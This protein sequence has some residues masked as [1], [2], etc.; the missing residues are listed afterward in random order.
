MAV[1]PIEFTKLDKWFIPKSETCTIEYSVKGFPPAAPARGARHAPVKPSGKGTP[2]AVTPIRPPRPRLDF[3]VYASNYCKAASAAEG[4]FLKYTFSA[5]AVPILETRGLP[6]L[7]PKKK[8][9][10]TT[11][12]GESKATEGVLK[13]RD[14]Q[15]RYIN[16]AFSPYTTHLRYYTAKESKDALLK[17]EPFWPGFA[18]TAPHAVDAASLK[19]KWK[20]TGDTG[21]KVKSGLVIV[22][23]NTDTEVYRSDLL[24]KAAVD[25]GEFDL[26][27]KWDKTKITRDKMPYRAQVIAYSKEIC[28]AAMHTEVRLFVHGDVGKDAARPLEDP[29]CLDLAVAPFLPHKVSDLPAEGTAEWYRLKL[30]EGGFHPGPVGKDAGAAR[31][32]LALKEFQR[33]Y[34]KDGAAPH[35]RIKADGSKNDD[36]KKAL[37]K[38]PK[39]ERP[40]F[41]DP[42][43][44]DS[45]TPAQLKPLLKDKGKDLIVWVDDRHCYT[46]GWS[47][48]KPAAGKGFDAL[49]PI[50]EHYGM[51][52]YRGGMSLGDGR[53]TKD[54]ASIARPWIPLEAG[55]ALL[56][57]KDQTLYPKVA[58][59][60]ITDDMRLA[61]GPIRVD[62]TFEE[63]GAETD[64]LIPL[65]KEG[66]A[67]K[68][69][70]AGALGAF[71]LQYNGETTA[72]IAC[73]ATAAKVAAAL[74]ALPKVHSKRERRKSVAVTGADG[75]PWLVNFES[76]IGG[77][78]VTT[79]TA[80][81][82]GLVSSEIKRQS[83]SGSG[84]GS[85]RD[86]VTLAP[87]TSGSFKLK[88]DGVATAAIPFN[89]SAADVRTALIAVPRIAKARKGPARVTV[90]G[91]N[92]GPYTI[93]MK[94]GRVGGKLVTLLTVD[95]ALL[96]PRPTLT[97]VAEKF[98]ISRARK[99]TSEILTKDS[100]PGVASTSGGKLLTNCPEK[101]RGRDSG[102]IRPSD[103]SKYYKVPFGLGKKGSLEPWLADDDTSKAVCTVT[104]DDLGQD[105]KKVYAASLGKAGV[106]LHPSRIAGD[107]YR[108][109]AQVSFKAP[110]GGASANHLNL[111]VLEERYARLPQA[112]TAALRLWRKASFRGYVCWAKTQIAGW[113]LA[114]DGAAAFYRA[115]HVHFVH[116]GPNPKTHQSFPV[117]GAN[118]LVS[119]AEFK[120]LIKQ[121]LRV[122]PY[123]SIRN[124]AKLTE[125]YVWPF[126]HKPH[127]GVK[128]RPG[129]LSSLVT[130]L[131]GK[132]ELKSW[133]K[134]SK[135]LIL[136]T[137]AKIESKHGRMRG[138]ILAEFS[139]SPPLLLVEY[140]CDKCGDKVSE[141]ANDPTGATSTTIDSVTVKYTLRMEDKLCRRS[142]CGPPRGK[143][144]YQ[145]NRVI[146][147]G[148]PLC[149][150]GQ[151]LGGSWVYTPRS[152]A[153]W[154]H[155]MGHHRH[156]EHAQAYAGK[157][158]IAPGGKVRQHDSATH[159]EFKAAG[160]SRW[161]RDWD[162]FCVMS[163]DSGAPQT[164]CGKC[165]LRNRGWGVE[166]IRNPDG[167]LHD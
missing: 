10:V 151:P 94:G 25:S 15:T 30:A 89:A 142:S 153:T 108:F 118:K 127:Y 98:K 37:K 39:N 82:T 14:K 109:R 111:K 161:Q 97:V 46:S 54:A 137:I 63:I 110:P 79:L 146:S 61:I 129:N 77:P 101:I 103:L 66:D 106:Y 33:S 136:L 158:S 13:P 156:F 124:D 138:H 162:R 112:H 71:K 143:Y 35:A 29:Q 152:E 48:F 2:K 75:G 100:A 52:N 128:R 84:A 27:A 104:H 19:I 154:A 116:E 23:D 45:Y 105:A 47:S 140:K 86:V 167:A 123:A 114:M 38:L 81:S 166:K 159:P 73:N 133:D 96:M 115:A 11:W 28:L 31:L 92:G 59:P 155:E 70:V 148:I 53:V 131:Y 67:V 57:Q 6:G 145:T 20:I 16:V 88:C 17:L 51:E 107:G 149:A 62:W 80:V 93:S 41:G 78:S 135:E 58:M 119:A 5:S 49:R 9:S 87:V 22:W 72:A 95:D 44:R 164:F 7:K 74:K 139:S 141:I 40:M 99:F 134:Y 76:K 132:I 122:G 24:D 85:R 43:T 42:A 113:E 125:G 150:I 65:G 32:T 83:W 68:I 130:W 34:P 12:K 91:A 163:Y 121:K 144:K 157:N 3:S 21:A 165:L 90:T 50:T 36:T 160:L 1:A 18:S 69:T 26:S 4:E 8:Y 120:A 126:L 55:P 147:G 117:K 64:P 60:A 56:S 102:G